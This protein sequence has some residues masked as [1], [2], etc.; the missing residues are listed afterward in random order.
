MSVCEYVCFWNYC[1]LLSFCM[2]TGRKHGIYQG[3]DSELICIYTC[4]CFW[5]YCVLLSFCMFTGKTHRICEG[6]DGEL[7]CVH[8]HVLWCACA[9]V[10]VCVDE[11]MSLCACVC[12]GMP[13]E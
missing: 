4:T 12:V 5:N 13:Q 1:V 8:V 7:I 2:F 9:S 6:Y 3:N 11:C 10:V